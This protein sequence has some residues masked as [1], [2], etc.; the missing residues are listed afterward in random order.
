MHTNTSV[1]TIHDYLRDEIARNALQGNSGELRHLRRVAAFIAR[2]AEDVAD[3]SS[4]RS[5]LTL[6]D[7]ADAALDGQPIDRRD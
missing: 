7:A 6:H 4:Q 3:E 2:V 5:F 1:A